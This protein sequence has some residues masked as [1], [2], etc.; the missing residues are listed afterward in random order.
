MFFANGLPT[1]PLTK[2]IM[3]SMATPCALKFWTLKG[4]QAN[5]FLVLMLHHQILII[6]SKRLSYILL[7]LL[8]WMLQCNLLNKVVI[9]F[10]QYSV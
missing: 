4:T 3:V 1:Y 2:A 9:N 6:W 5:R 8:I 10:N 7:N